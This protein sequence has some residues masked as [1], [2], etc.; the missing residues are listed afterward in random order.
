MAIS[1]ENYHYLTNLIKNRAGIFL[2]SDKEYLV[3]SRLSSIITSYGRK[4]INDFIGHLK[5]NIANNDLITK[6]VEAI[7]TNETYFV[8][9]EKV[10]KQFES[11]V[12]TKIAERNIQQIKIW[13][14]A[15]SFGQEPYSIAMTML[16]N[17][18]MKNIDFKI[19]ASDISS[20]A[21]D[22]AKNGIYSQFEVQR[23]LPIQWLLK[24]FEKKDMGWE[25]KSEIKKF[26]TFEQFNLM[27]SFSN[28]AKF[29]IIFCRNVLIYF[30]NNTKKKVL[31][32][33][34][35]HLNPQGFVCVG[36]SENIIDIVDKLSLLKDSISIY[37][38]DR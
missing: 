9:D 18:K 36:V 25:V 8:R 35:E 1:S 24:Y 38:L 16:E 13:S 28:K 20:Q 2:D 10:F 3:E 4:D 37:Q 7:T 21:I 5:N 27:D 12:L 29:D 26:V 34:A 30:D 6:V 23:G 32:K 19:L 31:Q 14:A 33:I 22:R 11:L 15:C 17:P